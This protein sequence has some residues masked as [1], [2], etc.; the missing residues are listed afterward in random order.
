MPRP[1]AQA[2]ASIC[3]RST[4]SEIFGCSF[5]LYCIQC[6]DIIFIRC[7]IGEEEGNMGIAQEDLRDFLW[8]LTGFL[9]V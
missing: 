6:I 8:S 5:D 1:H 3:G 7:L 4:S 9:E 2:V